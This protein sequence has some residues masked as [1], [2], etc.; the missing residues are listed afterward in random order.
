MQ[1]QIETIVDKYP[2]KLV[3][4][5]LSTHRPLKLQGRKAL[6]TGAS[7]GIGRQI[8]LALAN[9][10]ADVAINFSKSEK[11]ADE[12]AK[13]IGADSRIGR[14]FL[15]AGLSAGG[16]CFPRDLKAYIALSKQLNVDAS[17]ILAVDEINKMQDKRLL[18]IV[19]AESHR[20]TV[21]VLGL[22]FKPNTP[23]I[24]ASPGIKLVEGLLVN[25]RK[26]IVYDPEAMENAR[27]IFGR[28]I[29]Y[30]DSPR[31]C[32]KKSD[33]VVFAM[34]WQQFTISN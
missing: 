29:K 4:D 24:E 31:E 12:V 17:L 7:R 34:P 2:Q 33:V 15:K 3:L 6:V 19:L 27:E 26:V 20:S 28:K 16:F 23:T 22:S 5:S 25:K 13:V 11:D 10:G 1:N 9:E 32:I 30:A 21:G 14:K 8:A 18:D